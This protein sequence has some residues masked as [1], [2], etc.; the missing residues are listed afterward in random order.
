MPSEAAD[1]QRRDHRRHAHQQRQP[2]AIEQA[3]QHVAAE[4]VGAEEVG[5]ESRTASA[6]AACWSCTGRPAPDRAAKIAARTI[7]ARMR[8]AD[9][10][11]RIAR[12]LPANPPPVAARGHCR[13]GRAGTATMSSAGRVIA[14]CRRGGCAGSISVCTTS[15]MRLS[16]DE[17]HRQHQD[18]ALQ[19]RDVAA[20]DRVVHQ[21]AGARPGE[22]GLDQDRAA[23]QVAELD[24]HHR[25][26]GRRDVLHDMAQHRARDAGPWRA[27]PVT[28]SWLSVSATEART[29]RVMMP[30][31]ITDNVIAGRIACAPDATPV[32]GPDRRAV[33][34]R[35]RSPAARPVRPKR[36]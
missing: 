4:L 35:C 20:E 8:R 36:R 21:E 9:H 23:E 2:A 18:H 7:S 16:A 14:L 11:H 13:C 31:G 19:D 29:V 5:R 28:N 10:R 22:H 34:A 17:E 25:Q 32:P 24:A 30:S 15:T 27:A 3:R 1:Q 6:G 33:A 26:A 12:Q